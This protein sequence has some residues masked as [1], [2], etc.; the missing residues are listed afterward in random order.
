MQLMLDCDS[1]TNA[2]IG[3]DQAAFFPHYCLFLIIVQSSHFLIFC[4][5]MSLSLVIG[6]HF[7]SLCSFLWYFP[8]PCIVFFQHLNEAMHFLSSCLRAP[9]AARFEFR[10]YPGKDAFNCMEKS[11]SPTCMQI[12]CSTLAASYTVSHLVWCLQFELKEFPEG[13]SHCYLEIS[14]V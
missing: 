8:A 12:E 11:H 2:F 1:L 6:C 9:L 13:L 7:G 4:V 3:K 5:V 10:L 14:H